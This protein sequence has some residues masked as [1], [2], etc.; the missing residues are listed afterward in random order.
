MR[1]SGVL[2]VTALAVPALAAACS[3]GADHDGRVVVAASVFPLAEVAR[4]VGGDDVRVQ[5]LTPPGAEPHDFEPGSDDIDRIEDADVLFLLGGGFQPAVERAARRT[6]GRR[7]DLLERGGDPHVWLDPVA[8]QHLTEQVADALAEADPGHADDHRRRAAAFVAEL[9]RL[10][11]D[12]RTGLR[13]CDRRVIVTVHQAFSRLA[14]RYDL[15]Q[16]SLTGTAPE[17]EPDPRRVAELLDLVR[18]Q[19]ITTVFTEGTEE[20]K[21]AAALAREAGV[22]TAVLR[23]LEQPVEGGYL[24]GMRDN[25]EVLADALGCRG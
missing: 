21:A 14:D 22:R 10:H 6:D 16:E 11:D 15:R 12:Y 7:V 18:R 1:L 20:A 2:L 23:T 17:A 25:L 3:S 8:M 5:D 9:A 13:A 24:K 4:A 19:G